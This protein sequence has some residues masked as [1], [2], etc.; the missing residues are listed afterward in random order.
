LYGDRTG[1]Q[2]PSP[3]RNFD[4]SI[5]A[6]DQRTLKSGGRDNSNEEDLNQDLIQ[7]IK[8][9]PPRPE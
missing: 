1:K 5:S 7:G 8:C 9:G 4:E 3:V 2:K 6:G